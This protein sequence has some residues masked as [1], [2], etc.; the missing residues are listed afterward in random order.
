M[1][2]ILKIMWDKMTNIFTHEQ[3]IYLILCCILTKYYMDGHGNG[4]ES[5]QISEI[6]LPMKK[7]M[8]LE[9]LLKEQMDWNYINAC[10][11]KNMREDIYG[12]IRH[13]NIHTMEQMTEAIMCVQSFMEDE[14]TPES[15]CQLMAEMSLLKK[16]ETIADY[17]AGFGTLGFEICRAQKQQKGVSPAFTVI[18]KN[19]NYG[20][21]I[22]VLAKLYGCEKCN[23]I[24][25]NIL[26]EEEKKSFNYDL[27]LAD[28]PK[29]E[30]NAIVINP[31][32]HRFE[33]YKMKSVYA[34]WFFI[35]DAL[36]H[37]TEDGR[38]FAIVS[39]GALVRKNERD[40][41]KQMIDYDWVEAIITLPANLY[42]ETNMAMELIV[43]DR[44]KEKRGMVFFGSLARFA[45]KVSRNQNGI[46]KE[47]IEEILNVYQ[48]D[49]R[50]TSKI[51][52][53]V[54]NNEIV[55]QNYSLNTML[56]L[57]IDDLQKNMGESWELKE[58]AQVMRGVQI[59]PKDEDMLKDNPT[60][61]LLNV[62]NIQDGQIFYDE[63]QR[64]RGK[65]PIWEDKYQIRE[66]DIVITTKGSLIKVAIV[67][68]NPPL[69]YITGNLTII[70][71]DKK[72]Y[73][74]Y[75]LHEFLISSVGKK[76]MEGIQ[77]GSTI[78]VLNVSQ[79]KSMKVPKY[80]L[81]TAIRY[82]EQLKKNE[83]EH[84]NKIK[85]I[86]EKYLHTKEELMRKFGEE[87]ANI[88]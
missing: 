34:E 86:E 16:A 41:R 5:A 50:I 63:M 66:D 60:H 32:D 1:K 29:G 77:T 27:I 62:K 18:E 6:N 76:S 9:S 84:R 81:E 59:K 73:C 19:R 68:P 38:L 72:K 61:Y 39:K 45:Y 21:I 22:K 43:F 35:M 14:C 80:A 88:Q 20:K 42:T 37:L 64:I 13:I 55:Q 25:R 75:L 23:V 85:E 79:L 52:K 10:E 83:L 71:T 31:G 26:E 30:N 51:G 2:Q 53:W 8:S 57:E 74:P 15:V 3:S 70:R 11:F 40:V 47:S 24:N 48:M 4:F 67:P 33:G 54:S 44:N 78:R 58:V 36:S 7:T 82:E 46:T 87:N 69:A 56:Y 17:C 12:W 49:E 65:E 28:I